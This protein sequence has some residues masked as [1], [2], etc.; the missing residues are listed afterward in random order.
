MVYIHGGGNTAGYAN[1]Y[2]YSGRHLAQRFD[3]IVVTFNY[4]LGLFGWFSHPSLNTDGSPEDRS[5]NYGN[6]DTVRALEW[7][8]NNIEAFGGAPGNITLFGE[9]AGG[10]NVFALLASPT[11]KGM[12]HRA[13][14][15]SGIPIS[16][17]RHR[18]QNYLDDDEPGHA[19]S[20]R[21]VTNK[22]L[23]ADGRAKTRSEA[24]IQQNQMTD[25]ELAS[26]LRSK[27]DGEILSIYQTDTMLGVPM[28]FRDGAFLPDADLMDLF[29]DSA[30]YHAVPIIVGTNRDEF[31]PF[32]LADR[33]LVDLDM[34]FI[35]RVKDMRHFNAVAGYFNDSWKARG[36]DEVAIRLTRSQGST[37]YA[38]RFDWDELPTILGTDLGVLLGA[39]HASEIPFVFSSFDESLTS[40]LM[41]DEQNTPSRDALSDR[42][43]SYW[44]E[45]A[46]SGSPGRGRSG[47]LVEW[48]PW[49]P[50]P[51]AGKFIVFDGEADGGIRMSPDA[52]TF[53]ALRR[54]ILVDPSFPNERSHSR[55]YD[56]VFKD[57]RHWH[58]DEFAR[59][60]G[61]SCNIAIFDFLRL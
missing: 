54:R 43:S 40:R 23:M 31:R 32:F 4:R 33:E 58:E 15:Q 10:M 6:L 11:A 8:Q 16:T 59:L 50:S 39:V 26:Y 2:K 5:G 30:S 53:E 47:N 29:A 44:A 38:Y 46:H 37:V 14:V 27:S 17:P 12:F 55:I 34:G 48:T 61:E 60:G 21:E 56:C 20:S 19:N 52:I 42:M 35:P 3:L 22:L 36:V 41:F 51:D 25:G 1:Q 57:S 13:I 45:F 7:V 9:S 49:N 18:A 24:I 28:I